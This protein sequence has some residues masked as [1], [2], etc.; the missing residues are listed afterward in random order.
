MG[1]EWNTH[2]RPGPPSPVPAQEPHPSLKCT[3]LLLALWG[4]STFLQNEA[5]DHKMFRTHHATFA[6]ER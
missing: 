4:F 3:Q 5:L 2:T 1:M 6:Q